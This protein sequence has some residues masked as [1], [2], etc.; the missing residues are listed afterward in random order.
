VLFGEIFAAKAR[1][2]SLDVVQHASQ[3]AAGVNRL[4][5]RHCSRQRPA[6]ADGSQGG[7]GIAVS[8]ASIWPRDQF[9]RG[10]IAPRGSRL[11][12][13]NEF[14]PTSMPIAAMAAIDLFDM[15]VLR[16]TLASSQHHSPARG[17]STAGPFH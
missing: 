10:T 8:R 7:D 15:A 14:L 9:C 6:D 1:D 13:S 2:D 11:T 5:A 17:R 3:T 16:L 12:T 4:G